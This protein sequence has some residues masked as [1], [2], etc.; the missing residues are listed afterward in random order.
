MGNTV[1][2]KEF[3]PSAQGDDEGLHGLF[4]SQ[5]SYE[6]LSL[7]LRAGRK[8]HFIE[9]PPPGFHR[10]DLGFRIGPVEP[11]GDAL[12]RGTLAERTHLNSIAR[13]H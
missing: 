1:P 5:S 3:R 13:F 2:G 9:N 7:G 6:I 4:A 12:S 8:L 10:A 11:P